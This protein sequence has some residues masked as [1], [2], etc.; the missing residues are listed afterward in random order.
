MYRA[1][2]LKVYQPERSM[3]SGCLGRGL[4][5]GSGGEAVL[6]KAVAFAA[7]LDEMAVV[8]QAIEECGD[9]RR[10]AEE[11]RPIFERAGLT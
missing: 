11:F 5:S 10:V 2:P 7:D 3:L 6:V 9:C 1:W 4:P 8:H